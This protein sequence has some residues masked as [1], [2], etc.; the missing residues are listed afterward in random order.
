MNSAANALTRMVRPTPIA[1]VAL[2]VAAFSTTV[3]AKDD[4]VSA[5]AV[6]DTTAGRQ[7]VSTASTRF[8][9]GGIAV[10]FTLTATERNAGG[11]LVEGSEALATFRVTDARTGQALTGMRPRAWMALRRSESVANETECADKVKSLIGGTLTARADIDLNSYRVLTLNNDKTISVINPQVS[12]NITKLENLIVLP[13]KGAD[14]VLSRNKDFLYVTMPEHNSVAVIDTATRKLLTTLSTG[15]HTKPT[16]VVLAPDGGAVWVGLDGVPEVAVI[17]PATN[18]LAA[19]VAAGRGLHNFAFNTGGRFAYVS[20][21]SDD[22]VSV[23][24][25]NTRTKTAD[26]RVGKTPVAIAYSSASQSIYVAALN[27]NSISVINPNKQQIA[28]S[29]A[30]RPGVVALRF[31]P[32]GRFAVA[33]NQLESTVSAV[34]AA[35]DAVIATAVVVKEP[36]Q[37]VF[38]DRYAYIRGIGSE[39]FSLIELAELRKGELAP[40]DIQAGRFAPSAEPTEVGV[41]P[42]IAPTI[43]GNSVMIANAADRTM[44]FYQ[45]GMMAPMGTFSN[46]NRMPHGLMI[47]DRSLTETAPGVYSAPVKLT[48]GGRFDVPMLIDQPRLV[49]CFQ[50]T[51]SEQPGTKKTVVG[52]S[53][54]VEALFTSNEIKP[55][56]SAALRFKITDSA[57]N[58]A[59]TGLTDVQALVFMPPGVWQ[60]RRPAKEIGG[61]VYAIDQVF[62]EAGVYNVMLAIASRGAGYA[63]LPPHIIKVKGDKLAQVGAKK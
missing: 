63:D 62:P 11:A 28:K 47:L 33:V 58:L 23:I 46:Y 25:T 42:M 1:L 2:A 12:F 31:D 61:G 56:K 39:K 54:Q 5:R 17:D 6:N 48:K 15:E 51:V 21:S 38:T 26:I 57:T 20:N 34:D 22:T 29:I 40:V 44:Y 55:R 35:T 13:E 18:K 14:W 30:V 24:D 60:Q 4:D 45:E 16:R 9:K 36:D 7:N 19:K 53:V 10:S 37:V 49:N 59:V 32:E 43:E 50:V 27:A 41:A 3:S 8:E 52:P